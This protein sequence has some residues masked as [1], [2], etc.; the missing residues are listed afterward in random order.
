M[1]AAEYK[2]MR[3][4]VGSQSFVAERLGICKMT[5]SNR[6]R[7]AY[8]VSKEAELALL[9]LYNFSRSESTEVAEVK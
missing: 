8:D 2:A 7:G 3:E 9:H 4:K 6:E 1:E 5:I